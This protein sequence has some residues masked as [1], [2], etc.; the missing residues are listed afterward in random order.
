[1]ISYQC[2]AEKG[3]GVSALIFFR[4]HY[5]GTYFRNPTALICSKSLTFWDKTCIVK[6]VKIQRELHN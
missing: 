3:A 6:S 2:K 4:E 5:Y 1:M